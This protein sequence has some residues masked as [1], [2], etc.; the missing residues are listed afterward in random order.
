M[1]KELLARQHDPHRTPCLQGEKR[2]HGLDPHALLAAEAAADEHRLDMDPVVRHAHGVGHGTEVLDDLG[3]D[4]D[5]DDSLVVHPGKPRFGFEE[6]LFLNLGAVSVLENEIRLGEALGG[7]A[8]P[9][10]VGGD[11]VAV[12]LDLRGARLQSLLGREHAG[13]RL[14]HHL[15]QIGGLAGDL[16]RLRGDE[17]DGLAVEL[18]AVLGEDG[19]GRILGLAAGLAGDVG[20]HEAVGQVLG[21][22]HAM[23]ARQLP[24]SPG[25]DPRD[26]RACPIGPPDHAVQHSWHREVAGEHRLAARLARSVGADQGLA[27]L[28]QVDIA[29][30]RFQGAGAGH[31]VP[32]SPRNAAAALRTAAKIWT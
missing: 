4:L 30:R 23:D 21:R 19:L 6:R 26:P 31:G 32:P 25:I 12:A 20:D 7:V 14:V 28:P 27:D 10:L 9:D 1:T 29:A 16:G 13:K 3:R 5:V 15:D 24:G 22:Q 8:L 11:H 17:G 2:Q 18:H